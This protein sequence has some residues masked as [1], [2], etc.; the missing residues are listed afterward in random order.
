MLGRWSDSPR[1][2]ATGTGTSRRAADRDGP[3]PYAPPDNEVPNVLPVSTVL[4]RTRHAAVALVGLRAYTTGFSVDVSVRRRVQ[5]EIAA[6]GARYELMDHPSDEVTGGEFQVS[7][8]PRLW[9]LPA[10]DLA[11]DCRDQLQSSEGS[12]SGHLGRGLQM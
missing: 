8:V 5:A 9:A 3:P 12:G 11:V 7:G 6:A 2:A 4:A 1:T 10:H